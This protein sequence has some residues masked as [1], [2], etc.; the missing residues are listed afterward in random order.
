MVARTPRTC[1]ISGIVP[2][3]EPGPLRIQ[4]S[5]DLLYQGSLLPPHLPVMC[6]PGVC[7]SRCKYC[8]SGFYFTSLSFYFSLLFVSN[9]PRE[10]KKLS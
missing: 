1:G 7:M 5:Q 10:F 2:D 8:K 6:H 9:I 3:M 4:L